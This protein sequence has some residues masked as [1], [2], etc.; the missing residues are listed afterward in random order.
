LLIV[1]KGSQ[2]NILKSLTIKLGIQDDT[3]FTGF[4]NYDKVPEYHNMLDIGVFAS[5]EDSES[6]GVAVLE[7]SACAKPVIVSN[8]GG[9]P[10]V[11]E[12]GKT[13]FVVEKQNPEILAKALL[14]LVDDEELRIQIGQNGRNKV[15]LQ[16][17]WTESVNKMLA[18]Y[19]SFSTK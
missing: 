17:S 8:V 6:F 15:I 4:I 9:L 12:D 7:A 3:V 10:E 16:Y 18:V 14:N 5:I 19:N 1:G 13:G 2:E 11:V